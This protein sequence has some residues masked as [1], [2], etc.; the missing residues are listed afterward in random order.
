MLLG[1][2]A[3]TNLNNVLKRQRHH[4]A[5]KGSGNQSYEFFQNWTL[6]KAV[7]VWW[8]SHFQLCEPMNYSMPGPFVF[9]YLPE[10]AQ[11][12]ST[13]LVMLSFHPYPATHFSFCLQSF[14]ASGSFSMS[15]LVAS[16]CQNSGDSGSATVFQW[17]FRFDFL[18]LTGLI[19]L[20]S[21]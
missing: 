11:I 19:S 4:I 12:Q 18:R 15:W 14:P 21:K 3:M 20:H 6:K 5:S 8:W 1:T 10:F 13:E 16:G 7:T 2:R 17:I 9:Q